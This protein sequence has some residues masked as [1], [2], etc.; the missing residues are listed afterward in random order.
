MHIYPKR[1]YPPKDH[2]LKIML[3]PEEEGEIKKR[4]LYRKPLDNWVTD[5]NIH[6][7]NLTPEMHEVLRDLRR[8]ATKDGLNHNEKF[9]FSLLTKKEEDEI[10]KRQKKEKKS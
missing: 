8:K 7:G 4:A 6:R 10:K 9:L 1:R 3:M 2:K 5:V